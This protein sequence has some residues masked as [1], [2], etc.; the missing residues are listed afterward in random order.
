[1]KHAHQ[2][3]GQEQIDETVYWAMMKPFIGCG[4]KWRVLVVVVVVAG[5]MIIV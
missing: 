1:M 5:M 3:E 4:A 2:K